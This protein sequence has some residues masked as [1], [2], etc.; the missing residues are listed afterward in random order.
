MTDYDIW[1]TTPPDD[2]GCELCDDDDDS[3]CD[4][5]GAPCRC[6]CECDAVAWLEARADV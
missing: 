4:G 2:D 6:V 1:K 5:C 3:G